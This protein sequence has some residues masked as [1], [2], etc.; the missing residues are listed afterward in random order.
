MFIVSNREILIIIYISHFETE[1]IDS[2]FD[3]MFFVR[4]ECDSQDF[5][6]CS[7]KDV[8][9]LG[10]FLRWVEGVN[11]TPLICSSLVIL[12]VSKFEKKRGRE[13][14]LNFRNFQLTEF[15]KTFVLNFFQVW[16]TLSCY[17][18]SYCIICNHSF[19]SDDR[20]D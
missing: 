12:S 16:N 13:V 11:V 15:L 17:Y 7:V 5:L 20:L 8:I 2:C 9:Y 19:A 14:P 6:C 3:Q 18:T 4:I 1:S 10:N